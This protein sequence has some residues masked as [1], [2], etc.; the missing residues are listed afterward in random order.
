VRL[1]FILLALWLLISLPLLAVS[2]LWRSSGSSISPDTPASPEFPRQPWSLAVGRDGIA[3]TA[4]LPARQLGDQVEW[5]ARAWWGPAGNPRSRLLADSGDMLAEYF[6]NHPVTLGTIAVPPAAGQILLQLD[7]ALN[8]VRGSDSR[9]VLYYPPEDSLVLR[10]R[11]RDARERLQDE[12][13]VA[14]NYGVEWPEGEAL[15]AALELEPGEE[16]LPWAL[17][18]TEWAISE[19][20]RRRSQP[21]LWRPL[22]S[23]SLADVVLTDSGAMRRFWTPRGR[24]EE[25]LMLGISLENPRLFGAPAW[26]GTAED[27]EAQRDAARENVAWLVVEKGDGEAGLPAGVWAPLERKGPPSVRQRWLASLQLIAVQRNEKLLAG[28]RS[29]GR[30]YRGEE[31][32]RAS[33]EGWLPAERE[34]PPF[35]LEAVGAGGLALEVESWHLVVGRRGKPDVGIA[36]VGAPFDHAG[37]PLVHF[38]GNGPER[39]LFRADRPDGVVLRAAGGEVGIRVLQVPEQLPGIVLFQVTEDG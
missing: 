10:E 12:L 4:P 22:P 17:T 33:V 14:F 39:T 31:T 21:E 19:F 27:D 20:Q 23:R 25:A 32:F 3:W 15:V 35:V 9:T 34:S 1:P 30:A 24:Q 16:E 38:S 28:H 29:S 11:L 18:A 37:D 8:G 6:P 5:R 26:W 13:P 7:Y 36:V 2:M